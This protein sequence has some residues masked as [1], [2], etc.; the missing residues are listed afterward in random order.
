MKSSQGPLQFVDRSRSYRDVC[1]EAASLPNYQAVQADL[2]RWARMWEMFA[3]N[4]EGDIRR[5]ADSRELLSQV[6]KQLRL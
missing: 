3:N 6:N 1:I 2:I 5:I 4:L